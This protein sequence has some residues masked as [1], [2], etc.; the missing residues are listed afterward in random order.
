MHTRVASSAAQASHSGKTGGATR[1]AGDGAQVADGG[2]R[3]G[4]TGAAS[5]SCA[6]GAPGASRAAGAAG[7]PHTTD[8]T[9][10]TLATGLTIGASLLGC[11]IFT[12]TASAAIATK[13]TGATLA[14]IAAKTT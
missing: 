10:A 9:C 12:V 7:T 3:R 8:A 5:A 11:A 1:T 13:T 6:P 2:A 14:T 4:H